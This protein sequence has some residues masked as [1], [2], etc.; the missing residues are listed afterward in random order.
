MTPSD[1]R[2]V[3]VEFRTS[4]C[5]RSRRQRSVHS[6]RVCGRGLLAAPAVPEGSVAT[7]IK[8][9]KGRPD[10]SPRHAFTIASALQ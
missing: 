5:L 2:Q 4:A 1:R 9:I 3:R 8:R 6:Q 7:T 10:W